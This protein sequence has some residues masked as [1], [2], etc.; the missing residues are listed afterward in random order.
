MRTIFPATTWTPPLELV[1][2]LVV[3]RCRVGAAHATGS[4]ATGTSRHCPENPC[5]WGRHSYGHTGD[6]DW[7]REHEGSLEGDGTAS[8][9]HGKADPNR[10]DLPVRLHQ[11]KI[12]VIRWFLSWSRVIGRF[13]MVEASGGG[14]SRLSCGC[15]LTAL[16]VGLSPPFTVGC[17]SESFLMGGVT[18]PSGGGQGMVCSPMAP[19]FRV[20]FRSEGRRLLKCALEVF[21]R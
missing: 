7:H 8:G 12:G 20:C 5:C 19:N 16:F 17:P 9:R 18:P 4:A 21:F 11:L 15:S 10:I 1:D 6:G 3:Y 14:V 2:D 13:P